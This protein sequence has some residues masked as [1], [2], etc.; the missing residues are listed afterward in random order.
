MLHALTAEPLDARHRAFPALEPAGHHDRYR[1]SRRPT[2]S[3]PRRAAAFNIRFNDRWTSARLKRLA[4]R[5]KLDAVGGRYDARLAGQRRGLPDPAGH[6]Q[7]LVAAAV[8]RGDRQPP[9]L[10]TTGGTSDARFI[11]ASARWSSSAWSARPCTRSTSACRSPT[12][13]CS[14]PSRALLARYF[15]SPRRVDH[16]DQIEA[17]RA[18]RSGR[19]RGGRGPPA[20]SHGPP[21][22]PA[23]DQLQRADHVAHL[24]VQ[25]R[26]RRAPRCGSRRRRG[27]RSS[28]SSVFTGDFAWHSESR[29]VVKSCVPDQLPRAVAA[30]PSASSG[31]PTCQT[32]PRS[33][34]GGARRL[35]MR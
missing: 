31:G 15:R 25:E 20:P 18:A 17:R 32:R 14:R 16:F 6:V 9:E 30:S 28:A 23:A 2:S 7:R 22:L 21:P 24:V 33:S 1:Q 34:A 35:R 12:S 27:A 4:R 26:A 19:R 11:R 8:E 29:K 5:A 3:R 13:R 10:S